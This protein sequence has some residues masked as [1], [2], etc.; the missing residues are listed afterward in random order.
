MAKEQENPGCL[1]VLLRLF[2][3]KPD[4]G[5][6]EAES[7]PYESNSR[8]LTPAERS[9]FGVLQDAYRCFMRTE[10]DYLVVENLFLAKSAQPAWEE[11]GWLDKLELD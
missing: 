3:A 9:F 5:A 6:K 2:G 8:L 1:G 11:D 7:F 10:M 4:A